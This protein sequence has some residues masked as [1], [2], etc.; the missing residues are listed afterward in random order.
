MQHA[1]RGRGICEAEAAG[2]GCR[3]EQEQ[4]AC[5]AGAGYLR[6][7]GCWPRLQAATIAV[8]INCCQEK[9]AAGRASCPHLLLLLLAAAARLAAHP[10]SLLIGRRTCKPL[11][12]L[13]LAPGGIKVHRSTLELSQGT[14]AGRQAVLACRLAARPPQTPASLSLPPAWPP[15]QRAP[16]WQQ[17]PSSHNAHPAAHLAASS[18]CRCSRFLA[19]SIC[20][21][22]SNG[23]MLGSRNQM[24]PSQPSS[25]GNHPCTQ[26]HEPNSRAAH[27]CCWCL[28]GVQSR[29]CRACAGTPPARAPAG[30]EGQGDSRVTDK[31]DSIS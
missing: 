12:P 19:S 25:A 3:Q 2:Q 13:S 26:T 6:G 11:L 27:C 17:L 28:P 16:A 9:A 21:K 8:M 20:S 31:E 7:R 23:N 1:G 14:R 22:E 10:S 30:M 15:P 4:G 5:R 18:A 29:A 24:L